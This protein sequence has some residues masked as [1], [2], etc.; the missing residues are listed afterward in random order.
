MFLSPS[1]F[2][3]CWALNQKSIRYRLKVLRVARLKIKLKSI[4]FQG[5]HCNHGAGNATLRF[6]PSYEQKLKVYGGNILFVVKISIALFTHFNTIFKTRVDKVWTIS[7]MW[8]VG[9]VLIVNVV[10]KQFFFC[11]A[12]HNVLASSI[13]I[14]HSS[15][16]CW[17][18]KNFNFQMLFFVVSA[19]HQ[20]YL[21]SLMCWAKLL[22][23]AGFR[24]FCL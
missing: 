24:M 11:F 15:I 14:R 19:L 2:L 10:H 5:K 23:I 22:Q 20:Y 17:S 13:N 9:T 1:A 8:T 4:S 21:K 12:K 3:F 16:A 7:D 18:Y 6:L